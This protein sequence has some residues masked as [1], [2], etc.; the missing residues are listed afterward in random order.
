MLEGFSVLG[1]LALFSGLG[2][3]WWVL[4]FAEFIFLFACVEYEWGVAGIL[5]GAGVALLLWLGA[6]INIFLVAFYHPIF[7]V[8]SFVA[9]LVVGIFWSLFKWKRYLNDSVKRLDAHVASKVAAYL[10]ILK[11]KPDEVIR[12]WTK[13]GN[14]ESLSEHKEA[15]IKELKEGRLPDA[16][17]GAYLASS[18][19]YKNLPTLS[20]NKDRIASWLMLWPWSMGW[21][22]LHDIIREIGH[23]IV[24]SL[25]KIYEKV[26]AE[27]YK[28]VDPRLLKK[29]NDE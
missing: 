7:T 2:F 23:K 13:N 17:M 19:E 25:R 26:I 28:D 6:D 11:G 15:W 24:T 20:E 9:Y 16:F 18:Y 29:D 1:L 10:A 4:L 14:G 8:L 22:V 27:A 12:W 5:S 21:Y 3:W